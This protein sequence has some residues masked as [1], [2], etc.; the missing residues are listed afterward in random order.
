MLRLR[1]TEMLAE[2]LVKPNT[3]WAELLKVEVVD[4]K[5]NGEIHKQK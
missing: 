1:A 4:Q 5:E 2:T 3:E